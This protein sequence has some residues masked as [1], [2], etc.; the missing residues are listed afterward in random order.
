MSLKEK[1]VNITIHHI[2]TS[3]EL[4]DEEKEIKE[5]LNKDFTIFLNNLYNDSYL[6][7][8][9][10][11]VYIEQSK[12]RGS[13]EK[14]WFNSMKVCQYFMNHFYAI[15]DKK[16]HVIKEIFEKHNKKYDIYELFMRI[17]KY[18][19]NEEEAPEFCKALW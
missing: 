10:Q 17:F 11:N 4:Y 13:I 14:E 19:H 9:Y 18:F 1:L 5:V 15:F 8:A 7:E 6:Q 16:N 2:T 3:L 12:S